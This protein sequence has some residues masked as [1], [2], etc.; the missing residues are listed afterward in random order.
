MEDTDGCLSTFCIPASCGDGHIYEGMETCDDG[1]TSENDECPACDPAFC[2]DGYVLMGAEECDDANAVEDDFCQSDCI[3][4]GFFEDFETG[5]L[6]LLPWQTSGGAD[7]SVGSVQKHAGM[8][9]GHSGDIYDYGSTILEVT[10][11]I[12]QA[13][14]ISFWH[15]ESSE[16]YF[17]YLRFQIDN[18]VQEEWSG[19]N[20]WAEATYP[21]PAGMHTLSWEY[22]KDGSLDNGDD[23]VYIDDIFIGPAP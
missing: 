2:G 20:Q 18:V 4:N 11:Q 13:G 17:D 10:L 12:P 6:S 1:N 8:F 15:M 22:Y 5:D 16:E 14:Q 9:A 23:T 3:A 21:I 19:L 7:W